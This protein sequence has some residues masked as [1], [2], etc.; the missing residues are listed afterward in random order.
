MQ[1]GLT[2]S[3][4]K[5]LF[6]PFV[7]IGVLDS[8]IALHPDLEG[9]LLCFRDFPGRAGK[10]GTR[11]LSRT[12]YDD[13]GHGTHVCGILAGSGR[14]SDKKFQG[15]FPGTGLVVGKVLDENGDGSTQEMLDGLQW[16]LSV[17]EKYDIRLLNISV[18]ISELND[19]RKERQLK[20]MLEK[21][22][23]EGILVVC[24]AGNRGPASG[25]LS[26]L[27]ES[28]KVISV[29]CHDGSFYRWAPDRCENYSG[30]GKLFGVPRKPD[31][32][33]PGT[34]IVSCS[35]QWRRGMPWNTAYQTRSGTSMAASIVTGCLA[36]ALQRNPGLDP[37]QLRQILLRSS[38]N[39]GEAW[40][41]QGWGMVQPRELIRMAG[42]A[43]E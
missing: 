19:S 41:K 11:N 23:A 30:C 29:G 13:Y 22:T 6:G 17:R 16:I 18:G 43:A 8:G 42:T 15:I 4:L 12:P 24:A 38:R 33:A 3:Y 10:D 35:G 5:Q 7:T 14:L 25:S 36:R 26:M 32:V 39:L 34:R 40:N 2:D 1:L 21:I 28:E 9:A 27:G 31:V 20:E 37:R